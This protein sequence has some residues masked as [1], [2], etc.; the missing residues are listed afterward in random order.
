[1]FHV[2]QFSSDKILAHTDRISEWVRD[3]IT[4]PITYELD[5]TNI[6]NH[7]CPMCFGFKEKS[8][9]TLSHEQTI[10]ILEQIKDC[11]GKAV[12]FTGGGES[13]CCKYTP[14]LIE[15][16][17]ALGLDVGVITNG[18]IMNERIAVAVM[19]SVLW[20][21]VSLDAGSPK[22][23]LKSHGMGEL[24]FRRTVE[25]IKYLVKMKKLTGFRTTVGLGYLT[26]SDFEDMRRFVIMG[27]NL[28]VDYV[29]FRPYLPSFD[30]KDIEHDTGESVQFIERLCQEYSE[31]DFK[32]L[33]SQHKYDNIKNDTVKRPY[34]KC[35]GH[36]FA[37]TICA[38]GKMYLCC[39]MRGVGKYCLGDLSKNSLKEIWESGQRRKVYE[40]IDFRDCPSLCR[41]DTFNVI[42]WNIK[43]KKEHVNFL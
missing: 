29:Q 12:T 18:S 43:Q 6:C 10:S 7:K 8:K 25:N 30:V 31:G 24:D 9:V 39:H 20:V 35:Y 14:E 19:G 22:G 1:M 34:G 3:G 23:Y 40:A 15:Y 2:K 17:S 11:G 32:V 28:G 27:K 13:F 36:H 42:L 4:K 16:A 21:R 37:T 26:P 5:M 38:D 41:C 33:Y